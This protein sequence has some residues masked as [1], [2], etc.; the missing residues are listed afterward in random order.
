M[1]RGL[2]LAALAA[3]AIV[4]VWPL[5][6]VYAGR[7]VYQRDVHL[8]WHAQVEGFVRAVAGGA[9]PLWDP[10]PSFGQPLLADPSAMISYPPTWLNLLMPAWAYYSV[11]AV[12]HLAWT[13]LGMF[14]LA[15]RWRM[16]E[17]AAAVAAAAWG[18]SGPVLS[19]VN[20]WHHFAGAAWIP[21]VFLAAQRALAARTAR[22]VLVWC[23]AMTA[24]VLAGSADMAIMTG[25]AI[26]LYAATRYV[27]WRRPLCRRNRAILGR[28]ALAVA[29]TAALSAVM[30]APALEVA[31]RSARR[32]LPEQVRTY[33]SVH[34]LGMLQSLVPDLWQ[35]MALSDAARAAMF[36][37]REQFLASLYLGASTL[38]LVA[39]ALLAGRRPRRRYLA[40]LAL[41][42]AL[43]ALG[44]HAPF[45]PAIVAA[46]P[47]LRMVRYP[48][49]AF[50]IVAFAWALLCGTGF[51]AWRTGRRRW[52]AVVAVAWTFAAA[53]A[54]A[55][56]YVRWRPGAIAGLLLAPG[57]LQAISLAAL[58]RSLAL[59]AA[60]A[61]VAA[62]IATARL[63]RP[64]AAGRLAAA[65]A[66]VGCLDLA[67][68]HGDLNDLGPRALY[69]RPPVVDL[70]RQEGAQRV[71]AY[72]YSYV[73]ATPR[74]GG[75]AVPPLAA[76]PPGWS[77]SHAIALGQ[78]MH[79]MPPTAG[80]W[81]LGTAYE[82]DLRGLYPYDTGQLAILLRR[83]EG[84]PAHTRLLQLGSATHV[85]S[86][87]EQGFERLRAV[88]ALPGLFA[89]PV[90]VYAVP[91][92]LP[93]EYAV[94]GVIPA[95]RVPAF[96]ALMDPGVDLRRAVLLP[97]PASAAPPGVAG[98]VE[99]LERGTDRLRLR[100]HME[101]DGWVVVTDAYDPG[102]K[103]SV[104]GAP[105]PLLNAN[106]AFRA[107]QVPAGTHDVEM[108]YRPAGA[109]W[110]GSASLATA[111]LLAGIALRGGRRGA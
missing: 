25:L 93:R 9:W 76:I 5:R 68:V 97:E 63:I 65:A 106:V 87:H 51:E 83:L 22:G 24:Q 111:L 16:S 47:P 44:R 32:A 91:D 70:L 14:L 69:A 109:I 12:T 53:A 38:A 11:F 71:Y 94:S 50:I 80:R 98:R 95:Q 20:L 10:V 110:G 6:G 30:W 31:L 23:A 61:A 41:G 102:W 33:W 7:V 79:L 92:P 59:C 1:K 27:R 64:G 100:A 43:V 90:R 67:Y 36:E 99:R 21:W 13:A 72:D 75:R 19:F 62:L 60:L 56:L 29:A 18:L 57:G 86:L 48:T 37:S 55:A 88:A 3:V 46:L 84:S 105:R 103:V 42:A 4:A 17:A 107:V 82:I 58:G 77:A 8:V 85:V 35:G 52:T 101:R 96:A 39:A 2:P 74:L 45:Y 15:R 26:A 34:P 73:D 89:L 40:L 54:A 66:V 78:Q 49:K 81:G 104:D 108:R 28:G